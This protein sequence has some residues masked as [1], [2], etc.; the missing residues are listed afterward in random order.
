MKSEK[1][2]YKKPRCTKVND[3][4]RGEIRSPMTLRHHR[5]EVSGGGGN[6]N[7]EVRQ[8]DRQDTPSLVD[9]IIDSGFKYLYGMQRISCGVTRYSFQVQLEYLRFR[10]ASSPSCWASWTSGAHHL[11]ACQRRIQKWVALGRWG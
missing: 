11:S 4:M 10:F 9:L 3:P 8:P 7:P 6:S 1:K 2:R 5:K